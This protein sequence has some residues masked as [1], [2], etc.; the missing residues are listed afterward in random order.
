MRHRTLPAC[1][2]P[3]SSTEDLEMRTSSFAL[4]LSLSVAALL[5]ARTAAA[6]VTAATVWKTDFAAAQE[7]ARKLNRP[8]VVHFHMP[9]CGPC[10]RMEK[11][12][13]HTPQVLKIIDAGFVGVKVDVVRDGNTGTKYRVSNLPTDMILTPEGKVL[14]KTEGYEEQS[15]AGDRDYKKYLANLN[16]IDAQYAADGK[17]LPRTAVASDEGKK[18]APTVSKGNTGKSAPAIASNQATTGD[19]LVPPAEFATPPANASPAKET[20]VAKVDSET[21]PAREALPL[22]LDGYC[23]VT[24][25]MTR[26]WSSG[27]N[28]LTLDHDG[29]TFRF[30]SAEKRDEFKRN[31]QRFAPRLRGCDPVALA[32]NDLAVRGNVKFG[33]LSGGALVLFATA[34]SR[35]TFKK[36]PARFARL[37]H[38]LRPADV[39]KIASASSRVD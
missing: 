8:I 2:H 16:R 13:L 31:P 28:D 12:V 38:A 19:K 22:A 4:S 1:G 39:E 25:R 18:P 34:E 30:T 6:E 23:P 33:A 14:V 15:R 20:P 36:D 7:E 26:G 32:T 29:Q 10:R 37:Q 21:S 27:R 9:T 17:R 24:L 35:A 5:F 11:E 3:E